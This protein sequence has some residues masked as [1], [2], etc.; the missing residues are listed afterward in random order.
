M[1]FKKELSTKI[2]GIAAL[3]V[4]GY[5]FFIS[6]YNQIIVQ[7]GGFFYAI[8]FGGILILAF[9]L[10]SLV[11]KILDISDEVNDNFMWNVVEVVMLCFSAYLFL[12]FRLSYKSSV[13]AEETIIYRAAALMKEKAISTKGMDMISHL[14]TYPSQYVYARFLSVFFKMTDTGSGAFVTLNAITLILTAFVMDRVVRRIAGRACGLLAALCTLFIPSQSFAVYSY[15]S[16]FFLCFIMILTFDILL[17]V[18]DGKK[19]DKKRMIIFDA[20]FGLLLGLLCFTEPLTFICIIAFLVYFVYRRKV[21]EHYPWHAFAVICGVMLLTLLIFNITKSSVLDKSFGE[22]VGGSFTRF[23]V[24]RNPET[25]E[26]YTF[27]EIFRLFHSNLDNQ[28]TNVNDNYLFL[29]GKDGESYTRTNS[30]WFTLG[31]Q[32]SYMFII[33][34][35]IACA[36]YMLRNKHREVLPCLLL[37]F[38]S[39]IMLFYRSTKENSTYFLFEILMIIGCTGLHYM[40]MN[41]HS[42]IPVLLSEMANSPT[43]SPA[44][45]AGTL[46]RAKALIF[47]DHSRDREPRIEISEEQAIIQNSMDDKFVTDGAPGQESGS[48]TDVTSEFSIFSGGV[49]D[50]G[51]GAF[52]GQ[53]GDMFGTVP[54]A[55]QVQNEDSMKT[56]TGDFIARSP[57]GMTEPAGESGAEETVGYAGDAYEEYPEEYSDT[58]EEYTD[59]D[60]GYIEE[61]EE[62]PEE[63]TEQPEEYSGDYT[64]QYEEYSEDNT[65]SYE[66]YPEDYPEEYEEYPEEFEEYPED[67]VEEYGEYPE[68]AAG[69]YEEYPEDAVEEYPESAGE[70]PQQYEEY[71]Q[72][73]NEQ[74][75]DGVQQKKKSAFSNTSH[76]LGFNMENSFFDHGFKEGIDYETTYFEEPEADIDD[77][78]PDYESGLSIYAEDDWFTDEPSGTSAVTAAHPSEAEAYTERTD[79]EAAPQ[80][81]NTAVS[82]NVLQQENVQTVNGTDD[83]AQGTE[84][85]RKK[86]IKKKVV[87]RVVKKTN[88]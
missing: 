43:M 19:R 4:L 11:T 35:S 26:K 71:Q 88:S 63:Y 81:E 32:M 37:L 21:K 24:S 87:R 28:N 67:Q 80:Q 16:E 85:V 2:I 68:E 40:Y 70:E 57:A 36:Y 22:V 5:I 27:G 29:E 18:T 78:L 30:A 69:E 20:L 73:K 3:V 44:T 42:D 31:T 51:D 72:E 56:G 7:S 55:V 39:F 9:V 25:D 47:V 53:V 15:S 77:P 12:I 76:A 58:Y 64:G 46:A 10:L 41:H 48:G 14:I 13:P 86:V 49:T 82:A 23:S 79:P 74:P 54:Q 6:V 33:V 38:G 59:A 84:T 65:G 62:Y 52:G 45:L 17:L 83:T 8:I 34:M 66:E 75:Q 60:G 50:Y 1:D 61:Y